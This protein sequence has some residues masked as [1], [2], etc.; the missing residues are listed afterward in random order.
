MPC[1]REVGVNHGLESLPEKS[2]RVIGR[3]VSRQ[4]SERGSTFPE[5]IMKYI[6]PCTFS[7]KKLDLEVVLAAA[8]LNAAPRCTIYHPLSRR[9][10][11]VGTSAD[12]SVLLASQNQRITPETLKF[13]EP[14]S[15]SIGTCDYVQAGLQ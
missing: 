3:G 2:D 4:L 12:I 14:N 7:T 1:I 15:S 13:E 8:T 6:S 10:Y 5:K 9:H 11:L